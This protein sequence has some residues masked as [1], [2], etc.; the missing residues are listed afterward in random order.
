MTSISPEALNPHAYDFMAA[1]TRDSAVEYLAQTRLPSSFELIRMTEDLASSPEGDV[2][3]FLDFLRIWPKVEVSGQNR[4][5]YALGLNF[6]RGL[7]EVTGNLGGFDIPLIP[8]ADDDRMRSVDSIR[9]R[10]E[11]NRGKKQ[12]TLNRRLKKPQYVHS[13][14]VLEKMV[15]ESRAPLHDLFY[16]EGA[17]NEIIRGFIDYFDTVSSLVEPLDLPRRER[18]KTLKRLG[19]TTFFGFSR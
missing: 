13:S 18:H 9:Q 14:K 16:D 8:M 17:E 5:L 12:S 15:N 1:V 4:I 10:V 7:L 11:I 19:M 3:K 6:G 2:A